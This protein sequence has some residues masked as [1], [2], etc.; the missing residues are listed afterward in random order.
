MIKLLVDPGHGGM[1]F[2]HYLTPGKRSPQ[3]PPG[4]YEGEFNRGVCAFLEAMSD[5]NVM[6]VLNIAPGP[7]NIP[8]ASRVKYANQLSKKE[9]C[10][11]VSVHANAAGSPG[12][13]SATGFGV[14]QSRSASTE[15]KI[16]AKHVFSKIGEAISWHIRPREIKEANFTMIHRTRCPAVLVE[17]GFMTNKQD[18]E[19]LRQ[20]WF[21]NKIAVAI[22][23]A[24]LGV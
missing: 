14:F 1:A 4:I 7:I 23:E 15:S 12:W 20:K 6:E 3:V 9:N 17:C 18:V 21:Q 2:G 10:V 16:L 22:Y 13:R 24:A 11:L 5:P 8:I 19:K